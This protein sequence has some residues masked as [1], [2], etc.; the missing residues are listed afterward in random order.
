MDKDKIF[1]EQHKRAQGEDAAKKMLE[2]VKKSQIDTKNATNVYI[3]VYGEEVHVNGPIVQ[4]VA[5]FETLAEKIARFDR[6]A[7]NVAA[8]R[9]LLLE[10][11]QSGVFD[12]S[13]ETP[14]EEDKAMEEVE[15]VDDFGDVVVKSQPKMSFAEPKNSTE[16]ATDNIGSDSSIADDESASESPADKPSDMV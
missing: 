2:N 14:E 3:N 9:A 16:G 12:D 15:S 13:E 4:P 5:K 10:L 6:L 1:I 8:N 7:A 11:S